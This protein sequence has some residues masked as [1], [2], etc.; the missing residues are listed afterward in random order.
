[1]KSKMIVFKKFKKYMNNP[2]YKKI[3]NK[4]LIQTKKL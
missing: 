4:I 1:M 3:Q 2:K